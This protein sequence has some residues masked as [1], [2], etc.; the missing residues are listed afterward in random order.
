MQVSF[1]L[2]IA[3]RLAQD[4]AVI[5][6]MIRSINTSA[7]VPIAQQ[8]GF[9][10]IMLDLEHGD[11]DFQTVQTIAQL[12]RASGLDVLVRVPELTR[13][14]VS[15]ALDCGVAGIMVPMLESAQQ[16]QNL[17]NWCKYAPIGKRGLATAGGMSSFTNPANTAAF[18]A[19][20]NQRV[21]AIAQIE[22]VAGV[23]AIDEIAAVPGLDALL[24][25]PNDLAVSLGKPGQ[26]HSPEQD[27]AVTRIAQAASRHHKPL[28]MHT[29]TAMLQRWH[30]LGMRLLMNS[31]DITM[32][33]HAMTQTAVATR[34][35]LSTSTAHVNAHTENGNVVTAQH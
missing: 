28:G 30:H 4:E 19:E 5:G 7:I 34:Q 1:T 20:S 15:R 9:D 26:I 11:H 12:G 2:S 6:T 32:L 35:L 25:G 29:D 21:L 3:Q 17:V 10:F 22:T 24:I 13:G 8:A 27:Q 18:M 16:A 31:L 23:E 14:Y 33:S